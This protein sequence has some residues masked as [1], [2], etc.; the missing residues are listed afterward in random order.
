MPSRS[1]AGLSQS[2]FLARIV[3]ERAKKPD[4]FVRVIGFHHQSVVSWHRIVLA[5]IA[6]TGDSF[7]CHGFQPNKPKGLM[8]AICQGGIGSTK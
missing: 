4:E 6:D 5:R 1:L 8:P 3:F 2:S 7:H